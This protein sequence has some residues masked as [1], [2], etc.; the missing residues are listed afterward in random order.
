MKYHKKNSITSNKQNYNCLN[1]DKNI[2][3]LT[4]NCI[5]C[6]D[7]SDP[8]IIH[9]SDKSIVPPSELPNIE[10]IKIKKFPLYTYSPYKLTPNLPPETQY[11]SIY[12]SSYSC[13]K[14]EP[15]CKSKQLPDTTLCNKEF[16]SYRKY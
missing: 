12:K 4:N 2:D 11:T 16:C 10:K 3:K 5:I 6:N 13:F 7:Y 9:N 8:H 14:L 15:K 1:S